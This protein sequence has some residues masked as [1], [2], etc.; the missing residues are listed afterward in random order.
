MSALQLKAGTRNHSRSGRCHPGWE[1]KTGTEEGQSWLD[2]L[3]NY[4][5]H[6]HS[7]PSGS[8]KYPLVNTR[9]TGHWNTA[10]PRL[11][12][13]RTLW[14]HYPPCLGRARWA[15]AAVGTA[16]W[17]PLNLAMDERVL[18]ARSP[19]PTRWTE[20]WRPMA[21]RERLSG[22]LQSSRGGR[23]WHGGG[24]AALELG[25]RGSHIYD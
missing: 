22:C 19:M 3:D 2:L 17:G 25:N 15:T 1:R 9:S 8:K 21:H 14:G 16:H 24:S 4:L 12:P 18:L 10:A 5:P 13:K 23:S 7:A 11:R 20:V 6:G